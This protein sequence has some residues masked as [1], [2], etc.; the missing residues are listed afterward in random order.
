MHERMRRLQVRARIRNV[1]T[2][3]QSQWSDPRAGL[4]HRHF[5]MAVF[6]V[7]NFVPAC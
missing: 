3:P 6:L 1:P 2:T 7:I 5:L 4:D